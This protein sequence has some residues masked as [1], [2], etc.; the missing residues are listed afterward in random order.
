M[1]KEYQ[2]IVLAI[3]VAVI[4]K[5]FIG[6]IGA[7]SQYLGQ[8]ISP[9]IVAIVLGIMIQNVIGVPQKYKAG[10]QF[11]AKNV[12][13]LAIVLLGATL[14]INDAVQLFLRQ[15]AIIYSMAF[16]ICLAFSI[17]YGFGKIMHIDFSLRTFIGGG[18]SICGGT[19]ISALGPIIRA[20]DSQIAFGMS[21]VFFLDMI[22]IV[23]Y[24][25]LGKALQL[26]PEAFG[27]LAGT[28]INDT[29]SVLAAADIYSKMMGN[30]VAYETASI[31]KLTRTSFLIL[32]ALLFSLIATFKRLRPL[33]DGDAGPQAV[34]DQSILKTLA[35]TFPWFIFLFVIMSS[36]NSLGMF[37]Q[38]IFNQ[39]AGV[40]HY[41]A[42]GQMPA[43]VMLCKDL[44]KFL[45]IVALAGVGLKCNIKS[46]LQPGFRP[47]ILGAVTSAAVFI[48]SMTTIILILHL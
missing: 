26:S 44:S 33:A 3:I 19:T 36:L 10:V 14:N 17:A 45:I 22:T 16:N 13:I 28:A 4:A 47:I 37:Q 5:A 32:V 34:G 42:N 9:T 18:C 2:G 27:V 21:I 1:I 20:T 31:V 43:M 15:P 38:G 24:P 48:S 6:V 40:F 11:A 29:S 12:L 23:L 7:F 39:I 8:I 35:K 30:D 41:S 46:L 25:M